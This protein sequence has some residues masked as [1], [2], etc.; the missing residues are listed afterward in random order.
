[1][2]KMMTQDRVSL[3]LC[4]HV[5][6]HLGRAFHIPFMSSLH[7]VPGALASNVWRFPRSQSLEVGLR[8]RSKRL[9]KMPL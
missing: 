4:R 2:T 8:S 3:E 5:E 9:W 1:M 7:P 6:G